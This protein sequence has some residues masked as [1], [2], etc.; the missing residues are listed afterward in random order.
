MRRWLPLLIVLSLL[1]VTSPLGVR[2]GGQRGPHAKVH[3][4]LTA[5]YHEYSAHRALNTAAPFATSNPLARF[6]HDSVL[7]DAVASGDATTL[8]GELEAMGMQEAVA[9]GRIVSGYLPISVTTNLENVSTL[10]F[11]QPSY[12]TTHVGATTSQGDF[13]MRA[14]IARTSFSVN[15]AGVT[16]GI[17]SDSFNFLGGAATDI[18]SG[19]LPG[20]GNPDGFTTAVNILAD[21]GSTDEGRAM[22]QIVHDV[23]P[24]AHLAFATANGGQAALAT[25]IASLRTTAGAN[26]I[27]DDVIYFAE[28]MFQDGIIAQAVDSV[29]AAGVAY[30]S[31]AGNNAR[32]AYQSAFQPGPALAAGSIPS[33]A[34]APAFRGGTAHNFGGGIIL[35]SVTVPGNSTISISFQWSSP[36]F[37]VSGA[38]GS[39]ND[40]DIYLLNAA[41]TQILAGSTA[42][43]VGGDPI[44]VFGFQNNGATANFTVMIVNFSGPNPGLMKYVQFRGTINT[45][46]TNSG[47]IYGH[48]NAKGAEA[49]GAAFYGQTPRFGVSPAVLESFSSSGTTPI[50]FDT[51]GHSIIDARS[52]KPGIVAPDGVNTTFFGSDVDGDGFPNFFGTS[53]AAPHAAAVA[54]LVLQKSPGLLPA[55]LYSVL[56]STALDMGAPGFDSDSGFGLIQADK[57][58]AQLSTALML[59]PAPGTTLA[60]AAAT[61][62]WTAGTGALQYSLSVGTTGPGSFNVYSQGQGTNQSVT[63]GGLPVDGSTVYVRLWTQLGGGSG[64][65]FNDYTYAGASQVKTV[66]TSPAPGSTLPGAAV[67]F[68]WSAATG[69]LQYSLSVGTTGPGSFNVYSQGQGTSLSATVSGL[70]VDDSP[71]YVRLWTQFGGGTG[72]LLNDY[73]YTA[74]NQGKAAL[75]SP[76]PGSTLPGA[77]ATFNWSAGTGA[78]QYSLSIGT[79]GPGSF[80]VYSQGQGT[81]LSA[82][83]SGLPVDGSQVYVRLWTQ[84]GGG[85]GWVLND[86]TY[87]AA[88]QGKAALTSGHAGTSSRTSLAPTAEA[89]LGVSARLTPNLILGVD[90]DRAIIRA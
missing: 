87:T 58:L 66:L 44:E 27:V 46:A 70:P 79:T 73:T 19:D 36:Y 35:Q 18:A 10:Q 22:A 37:S 57:A 62:S 83:V 24:G 26:V 86:Y 13:S 63:V 89:I 76:A 61:F 3:P 40:L 25:R 74:A 23:A 75:T 60:G 29:M 43:N 69:A 50:F 45:F 77:A 9:Y 28:P 88:N 65:V 41:G 72:W 67:T 85:T 32:R 90:I 56:E 8:Q 68:G 84:F 71:V 4:H 47:T 11:A 12:F 54:A 7:V 48:A 14:D 59:S 20:P 78:L 49:V 30:F 64:W 34:G 2:A 55:A 15:G 42:S 81:S 1:T 53:A 6:Q 51:S 5:L 39:P 52:N 17:L 38:P 80:N 31:S 21:S 16:V 33:A 82:T